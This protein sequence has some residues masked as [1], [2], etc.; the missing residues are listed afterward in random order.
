MYEELSGGVWGREWG[1]VCIS[2][3]LFWKGVISTPWFKWEMEVG[4]AGEWD[5][6]VRSVQCDGREYNL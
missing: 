2:S 6:M 1:E 3:L 4:K 5:G